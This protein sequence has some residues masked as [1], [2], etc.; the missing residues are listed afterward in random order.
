MNIKNLF[1]LQAVAAIAFAALMASCGGQQPQ[2]QQSNEFAVRTV[3]T[4]SPE[5]SYT[6]PATIKGKQDIEIRPRVSGNIV[7]VCV[8]EGANVRA[9]QTLFVIDDVNYREAVNQANAAVNQANA[10]LNQA[11]AALATAQLTYENKQQ[12][13]KKGQMLL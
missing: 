13:K 10:S 7:R 8:D 2:Q 11:N 3:T 9:G 4:D 12:L 1:K 5:L 6:Y